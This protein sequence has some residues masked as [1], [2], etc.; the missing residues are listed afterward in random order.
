[1]KRKIE[2]GTII[3]TIVLVIALVN[4][5]LTILGKSPL[6]WTNEEIEQAVTIALTILASIAAWWKNN[7]FTSAAKEADLYLKKT[8]EIKKEENANG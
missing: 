7:S 3:R 6:P 4:Q 1:M 5:A 8:K 2:T